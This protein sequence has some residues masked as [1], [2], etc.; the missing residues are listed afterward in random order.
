[1][2][3]YQEFAAILKE[4]HVPFTAEEM[5]ASTDH[6]FAKLAGDRV[7]NPQTAGLPPSGQGAGGMRDLRRVIWGHSG[8]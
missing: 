7:S 1:M 8:F 4:F 3:K 5:V 6:T 2:A